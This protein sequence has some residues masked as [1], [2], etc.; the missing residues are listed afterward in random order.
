[1]DRRCARVPCCMHALCLHARHV[2]DLF[3]A[4]LTCTSLWPFAVRGHLEEEGSKRIICG[5]RAPNCNA[6][7]RRASARGH[8]DRQTRSH[9]LVPY[10]QTRATPSKIFPLE[11]FGGLSLNEQIVRVESQGE[12]RANKRRS[13]DRAMLHQTLRC[14]LCRKALPRAIP[15]RIP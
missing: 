12:C 8:R 3:P 6:G 5:L 10:R 1:M 9:S 11:A 4:R 7:A 2:H 13:P 14:M 15:H